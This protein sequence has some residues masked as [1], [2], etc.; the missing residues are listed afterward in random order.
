MNS[1]PNP[2]YQSHCL[3]LKIPPLIVVS[4]FGGV[5]WLGSRLFPRFQFNIPGSQAIAGGIALIA[6]TVSVLGVVAFRRAKTTV[7]PTKPASAA[8]LVT[9]GIYRFTR[10]PMYLGIFLLLLA[11]AILL[12]NLA[13]FFVLPFFVLYLNRFQVRLEESALHSRFGPE[14]AAYQ[15]KVRRWL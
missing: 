7:N 1:R 8:T 6:I 13:A 15:S 11:G 14:F 5:A 10:N 4:V 2:I 9:G 3:D 12:Q